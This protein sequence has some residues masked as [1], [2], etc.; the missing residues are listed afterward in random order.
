[1]ETDTADSLLQPFIG[2]GLAAENVGFTP[3]GVGDL[4]A[5]NGGG[6]GAL[7]FRLDPARTPVLGSH[8]GGT[9]PAHL[10]SQWYRLDMTAAQ[11]DPAYRVLVLTVAGR[12]DGERLRVEFADRAGDGTIRWLSEL[13]PPAAAGSPAWRN[14][15]V[16]LDRIPAEA[17]AV[18]VIATVAEPSGAQWVALVPPRLP[19]LTTLQSLVGSDDPVHTDAGFAFPCQRPSGHRHGVAELPV[20]WITNEPDGAPPGWAA[21]LTRA[22]TLP[23]YLAHDWTRNWGHLRLLTPST[24]A[25]TATIQVAVETVWGATGYG[26]R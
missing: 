12:V 8:T 5:E 25:Q 4:P 11:Q 3:N 14:L 13:V 7:P 6:T 18:R 17:N 19:R 26:T 1:M 20:W 24:E 16:A 21:P 10:I 2:S 9:Q 15:P 23:A 22:H